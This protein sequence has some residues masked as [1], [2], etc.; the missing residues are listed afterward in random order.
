MASS[1]AAGEK[2]KQCDHIGKQSGSS[3]K[4]RH[5]VTFDDITPSIIRH[6]RNK[7]TEE[8]G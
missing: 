6:P 4:A 5:R 1:C 8:E 7:R 2:R 3:S